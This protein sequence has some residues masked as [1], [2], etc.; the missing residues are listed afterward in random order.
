MGILLDS[1]SM[2]RDVTKNDQVGGYTAIILF[3][4]I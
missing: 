2:F 3:I 1:A 4:Y